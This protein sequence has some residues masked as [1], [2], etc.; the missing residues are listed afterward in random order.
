MKINVSM[1]SLRP[2]VGTM[3]KYSTLL[4][5]VIITVVALLLFLPMMM[6]GKKVSEKMETSARTA[7]SV[8]SLVRN[9]PSR[10]EA[11]QWQVNMDEF[12][13]QVEQI[14]QSAIQASRRDLITYDYV[15]FPEP[16]DPS[17]QIYTEYGQKYRNAV[18]TLIERMNALDAPS[19]SEIR[20]MTGGIRRPG[21]NMGASRQPV[22]VVDP[23]VDGLLNARSQEITTYANP[24]VFKWYT[25]WDDYE[26]SGKDQGRLS[27]PGHISNIS[28]N[29]KRSRRF[30]SIQ[31]IFPGYIGKRRCQFVQQDLAAVF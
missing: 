17:S 31:I 13:E 24:A 11:E 29:Q 1:D 14:K 3:K 4:P 23:M 2:M 25:F 9:V 6:I 26:F 20:S 7:G 16:V 8:Q 28:F 10:S 22:D 30:R 19:D 21:M 15:I 5:S 12:A 18:E 27:G